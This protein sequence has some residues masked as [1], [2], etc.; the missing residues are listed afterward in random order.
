MAGNLANFGLVHTHEQ[1]DHAV[2]TLLKQLRFQHEL[3]LGGWTD[4]EDTSVR[5]RMD[6]P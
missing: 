1:F 5:I 2:A 4:D 3:Q 6:K